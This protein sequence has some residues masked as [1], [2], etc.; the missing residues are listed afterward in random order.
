VNP[1]WSAVL[2]VATA[3]GS[4]GGLGGIVVVI[5]KAGQARREL[6]ETRRIVDEIN[7]NGCNFRTHAVVKDCLPAHNLEQTGT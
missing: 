5:F 4:L 3:V 7:Q 1:F 6:T 2:A